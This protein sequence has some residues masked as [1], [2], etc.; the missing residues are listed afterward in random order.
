MYIEP[1]IIMSGP[2]N[3]LERLA[4]K[5]AREGVGRHV[6]IYKGKPVISIVGAGEN[7][8]ARIIDDAVK[9]GIT[10]VIDKEDFLDHGRKKRAKQR[11]KVAA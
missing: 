9:L 8:L 6:G 3:L 1:Q 4:M 10:E 2:Y 11:R 5:L 7:Q